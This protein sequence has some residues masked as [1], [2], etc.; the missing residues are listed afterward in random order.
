MK[1]KGAQIPASDKIK[2]FFEALEPY[3]L[4][5]KLTGYYTAKQILNQNRLKLSAEQIKH[6][7]PLTHPRLLQSAK[8]FKI[9]QNQVRP[10]NDHDA[11]Q[12]FQKTLEILK[13]SNQ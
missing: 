5:S 9:T 6:L 4:Q 3:Q 8:Y 2:N 13:Q 7:K 10:V 11:N 1:T 12:A